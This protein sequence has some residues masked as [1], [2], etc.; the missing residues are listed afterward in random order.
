MWIF[1]EVFTLK[2]LLCLS[3]VLLSVINH[4]ACM[5][6]F[7]VCRYVFDF[8]MVKG[9]TMFVSCVLVALWPCTMLPN[10]IDIAFVV[11]VSVAIF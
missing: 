4:K 7:A 9:K 10:S 3:Q 5:G 8:L 6:D 11:D 1:D 2:Y